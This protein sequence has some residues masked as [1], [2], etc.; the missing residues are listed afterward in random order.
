MDMATMKALVEQALQKPP[1]DLPF[2]GDQQYYTY[3]PYYHLLFL[4]VRH[5]AAQRPSSKKVVAVECGVEGGRGVASLAAASPQADVYGYDIRFHGM[6]L[7]KVLTTYSNITFIQRSSVPAQLGELPPIDI[8]HLDSA[9]TYN[10]VKTE[11]ETYSPGMVSGGV[12]LIDDLLQW[13]EDMG[14]MRAFNE[15]P[16][17][18]FQD[19][20]V[21][22]GA[23][24]GIV[25]VP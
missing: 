16:W 24:Y 10:Q 19:D 1:Q 5:M 6:E 22:P 17:P 8:L 13:E 15:I 18:K 11:F 4:L 20:R 14:V 2:R 12:I 3:C 9:Q 23:G 25:L 21:H 7:C